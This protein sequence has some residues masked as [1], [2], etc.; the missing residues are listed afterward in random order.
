M[1]MALGD[2]DAREEGLRRSWRGLRE[3]DRTEFWLGLALVFLTYLQRTRPRKTLISRQ[4]LKEGS[5]IVI[6][7]TAPGQ[8]EV[9]VVNPRP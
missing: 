2:S 9:E 7:N 8:G 4:E 5:A 6:R 3:G 1:R